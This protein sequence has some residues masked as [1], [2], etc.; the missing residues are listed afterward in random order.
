MRVRGTSTDFTLSAKNVVSASSLRLRGTGKLVIAAVMK[1]SLPWSSLAA[2]AL[3]LATNTGSGC[4]KSGGGG[5][6][7]GP[8]LFAGG[9]APPGDLIKVKAGMTIDDVK[10]VLPTAA[11]CARQSGSPCLEIASGYSNVRYKVGFYSDLQT[12]A[13]ISVAS[14][15]KGELAALAIKA[16]GPGTKDT[17]GSIV[18]TSWRDDNTGFIATTS[19]ERDIDFKHFVPLNAAYFGAKPGLVGPWQ[20]ITF[21][22]TRDEVLAKVPGAVAPKGGGS[23][24]PIS[25]GP[26]GVSLEPKF[27]EDDKVNQLTLRF[28][29]DVSAMIEK[30]WGPGVKTSIKFGVGSKTEST[31]VSTSWFDET[32]GLR[33]VANEYEL[34][35][36]PYVTYEA[37]LGAS[38]DDFGLLPVAVNGK[39][40]A[41]VVAHY[42][43]AATTDGNITVHLA[44]TKLS[45]NFAAPEIT[46]KF[47][48]DLANC[49]LDVKYGEQTSER[50]AILALVKA[51]WGEPKMVF[52][53]MHFRASKPKIVVRDWVQMLTFTIE[54]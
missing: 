29:A 44:P 35:I 50:D 17:K 14:T 3:A 46:C 27:A 13:R 43:L 16:W 31:S 26:D 49:S 42:K 33:F 30:A 4:G 7:A 25:G 39:T 32:A 9:I 2:V 11:P 18:D 51:K 36:E 6:T 45:N 52:D 38:K 54:P 8:E 20:G 48:N 41:E 23:Y 22:M 10:K 34:V 21:G 28:P 5:K 12:V 53:D 40:R 1:T 24:N 37:L 15:T 47:T 19:F